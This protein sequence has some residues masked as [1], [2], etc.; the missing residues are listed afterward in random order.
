[1]SARGGEEGSALEPWSPAGSFVHIS[2]GGGFCAIDEVG[3]ISCRFRF[4]CELPAGPFTSV[5][6]RHE[7][8]CATRQDGGIDCWASVHLDE[9]DPSAGTCRVGTP[10]ESYE[11]HGLH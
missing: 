5:S 9:D 6:T 2:A 10:A 11:N 1:M 7:R 3:E 8:T 4:G